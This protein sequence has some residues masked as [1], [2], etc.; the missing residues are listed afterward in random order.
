MVGVPQNTAANWIEDFNFYIPDTERR[1]DTYY[2]PEAIDVLKFIKECKNQHYQ[3]PEI[4]EM[5]A[6]K[7]FPITIEKT[8]EDVQPPLD[9]ENYKENILTVMQTVGKTVANVSDQKELIKVL[10]EQQNKQNKRIKNTEKQI[11][12]IN[13]LKQEIKALKQNCTPAQEYEMKKK[14]FAMLFEK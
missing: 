9:Q 2:H 10:Q 5:L 4:M 6:N 14:S 1:D 3:K 11:E 13:E 7:K 8:K 12:K